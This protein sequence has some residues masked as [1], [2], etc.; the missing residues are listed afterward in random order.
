MTR[1]AL[2]TLALF[3]SACATDADVAMDEPADDF[4]API[5]EMDASTDRATWYAK[6]ARS[7]LREYSPLAS[8]HNC[9]IVSGVFAHV[10]DEKNVRGVLLEADGTRQ[11]FFR[12][13]TRYT[14][15]GTGTTYGATHGGDV[16]GSSYVFKGYVDGLTIEADFFSTDN[17]Q[18]FELFADINSRGARAYWKGVVADCS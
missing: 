10:S 6:V 11:S 9:D 8:Q 2:T 1:I 18:D 17:G 14:A 12:G 15:N 16:E 5:E 3:A 13:T 4:R 7:I